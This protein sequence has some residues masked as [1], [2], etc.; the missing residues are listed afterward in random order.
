MMSIFGSRR[1]PILIQAE[2]AECGLCCVAMLSNYFGRYTDLVSFRRE[3]SYSIR[4]A[5]LRSLIGISESIGLSARPLKLSLEDIPKLKRPAI[6]HWN[7]DH[8]VVLADVSRKHIT[9][10]DPAV[11][12]RKYTWQEASRH[13]SGIALELSPRQDFEK[14]DDRDKL[15]LWT[16]WK[17]TKR[18]GSSIVVILILSILIQIF[19][20]ATPFYLQIVVDDVLVKND[21]DLLSVL[22]LGFFALTLISVATKALRGFANLYLVNQLNYNIGNSLLHHLIRLPMSYFEKRHMGDIVSRFGSLGPVRDFIAGSL[23]SAFIDGLLATTTLILMYIYSPLLSSVVVVSV[24]AYALFRFIQFRP[25]RNANLESIA[26]NAELDSTFMESIRGIQGIKLSCQEIGRQN[27]WRN[28]FCESLNADAKVG[29]LT[30][31]YEAA[32]N[33]LIGS[34]YVLIIFI[35]AQNVLDGVITVGMLYAFISYRTNFSNAITAIINHL[36]Q[37][38]MLGLHMERLSDITQTEKENGLDTETTLALPFKG[39]LSAKNLAFQYSSSESPVFSDFNIQISAGEFVAL[40]GP[41][42]IGKTTMLKVLMNLLRPSAGEIYID[43]MPLSSLSQ[44]LFR[45]SISAVMQE[46]TLFSGSLRDNIS[47]FG[48][49]PDAE[50]IQEVCQLSHVHDDIMQTPM[51]YYSLIGDM[52][53]SLSAG[54]QQRVLIARALYQEPKILF[55]DEGTSHVDAKIEQQI[56]HTLKTLP[57]SCIFVTHNKDILS[58]A[59]KVIYWDESNKPAIISTE[60]STYRDVIS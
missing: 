38:R 15:S 39:E 2:A 56:M 30:I 19:T 23:V 6:L 33:V 16:F 17:G 22:A 44:R 20:L 43:G 34:E 47:F 54:Q 14:G 36:I 55:M 52:G 46:D 41:S 27:T 9:I 31:S 51:G 1:L 13:F 7:L 11:G 37:Y 35:G 60:S 59:D 32:N 28:Q 49:T 42:G 57:I 25:L 26:A 24:I 21:Q 8:Y 29:R 10:H 18:L 45:Q 5:T 53:A 48:S 3:F 40:Y 4:G 58:F 50:R 12:I